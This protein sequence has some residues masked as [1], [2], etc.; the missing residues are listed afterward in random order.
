MNATLL[1]DFMQQF[2]IVATTGKEEYSSNPQNIHFTSTS[3]HSHCPRQ[4]ATSITR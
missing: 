1:L 3:D 4:P 2:K